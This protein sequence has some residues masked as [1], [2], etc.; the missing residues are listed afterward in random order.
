MPIGVRMPVDSMSVRALIGIVQALATPGNCSA[1]SSSAMSVS[2]VMPGRHSCWG[3]RLMVV[4]NISVGAGSV[5]VLAR[6][7]LPRT[8]ATSGKLLMILSWVCISS[9]AL[10]IDMPGRD[11]GM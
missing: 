1:L 11:V 10:V 3:L 7:A 6:P 4:S 9:A 2:V 5:A 8:D